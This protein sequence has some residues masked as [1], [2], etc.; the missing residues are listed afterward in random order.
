MSLPGETIKLGEMRRA[1]LTKM[2]LGKMRVH[3]RRD[4]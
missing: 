3:I 1:S 2:D 4:S